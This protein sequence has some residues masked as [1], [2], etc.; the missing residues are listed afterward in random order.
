[1]LMERYA[2]I[3]LRNALNLKAGDVLSIN[4]EEENSVFAHLIARK[5][6]EITG[7]GSYI[8]NIEN[9][10]VTATEEAASDYAIEKKP[11]ALLYLPVYRSYMKAE[12]GK[13][14][15]APEIQRFRHLSDPLDN[16]DPMIPF[17]S[18]PV[19]S[20]D[21]GK[22]LDEDGDISLPSTLLSDL[23]GLGEDDYLAGGE[24][25][26]LILYERDR[27]NGFNLKKGRIR[28]EDGTDLEFSFLEGS[29]FMSSIMVLPDGRKFIPT[30]YASDIFRALEKTSAEGYFTATKPF[31]LFGHIVRSFS[32]RVE[33]G[34][35]TDFSTDSVSMPLF[36]LFLE[37]D[38]AA[39]TVSE[40]T[41]AEES[42]HASY[43]EYFALPEWDRMRGTSITIGGPRPESLKEMSARER[44]NDSL[45]TLS[46]PVGSDTTEITAE[47]YDGNE[48]TIMEDGYIKED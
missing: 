9:G 47:D 42:T 7:N 21:W 20:S 26:D 40:L 27:L 43:I 34:K 46:I 24:D 44:A 13:L 17:A 16:S 32:A 19:P 36:E 10:K 41:L 4:T 5:A 18:A 28:D 14:F 8:Q 11:T 22:V 1:M 12:R 30:I 15:T 29:Q 25:T 6:R 31:M 48:Y 33:H 38:K 37:Q 35:I 39:G 2:D 45:V 23:L 3:I